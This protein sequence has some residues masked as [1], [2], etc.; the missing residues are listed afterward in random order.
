ML[1]NLIFHIV[2]EQLH[3]NFVSLCVRLIVLILSSFKRWFHTYVKTCHKPSLVL[4]TK[5]K[6]NKGNEL[7][8]RP[9]TQTHF[10][11]CEKVQGS[12]FEHSQGDSQF[13]N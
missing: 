7:E 8:G 4:A 3:V 5:T 12:D 1:F 2:G 11:K 9:K 6:H 10:H 13:R